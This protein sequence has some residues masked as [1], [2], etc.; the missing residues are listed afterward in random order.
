MK[1]ERV[2]PKVGEYWIIHFDEPRVQYFCKIIGLERKLYYYV[3]NEPDLLKRRQCIHVKSFESGDR[4][5]TK[6]EVLV[7]KLMGFDEVC[8]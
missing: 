8:Y 3:S 1:K 6:A 7:A 5:A 4:K 2:L